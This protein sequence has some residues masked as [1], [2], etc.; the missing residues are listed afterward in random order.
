MFLVQS[1]GGNKKCCRNAELFQN[2]RR[3]FK[4]VKISVVQSNRY[5]ALRQ[6]LVFHAGH[7]VIESEQLVVIPQMT[8]MRAEKIRRNAQGVRI[9]RQHG[10]PV[11]EEDC[12]A[13]FFL[14]NREWT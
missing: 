3:H 7:Q 14:L 12:P 4:C 9:R 10:N 6:F 1:I 2:R 13:R 5:G 11:I 8:H